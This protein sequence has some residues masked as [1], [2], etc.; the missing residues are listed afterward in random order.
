MSVSKRYLGVRG[1]GGKDRSRPLHEYTEWDSYPP[2]GVLPERVHV[3][4]RLMAMDKNKRYG[5]EGQPTQWVDE[6]MASEY[7]AL[8]EFLRETK[9]SDQSSRRPGCVMFVV[10]GMYVKAWVH[11]KD[12]KRS[13][14][15]SGGTFKDCLAACEL[16]LSAGSIDWRGDKR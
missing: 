11:D 6:E 15:V 2:L 16:G 5:A 10:E 8:Y 9:W 12:G 1:W 7:P 14:W 3:E 4:D 13:G